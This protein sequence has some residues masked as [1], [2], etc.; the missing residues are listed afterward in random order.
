MEEIK[1]VT[2]QLK[3]LWAKMS[4]RSRMGVG[5]GL[6]ITLL[7]LATVSLTSTSTFGILYKLDDAAEAAEVA[8]VLDGAKIKYKSS[9]GGTV[10]E[11]PMEDIDRARMLLASQRLPHG[12]SVGFSDIYDDPNPATTKET[13]RVNF[14]RA[15]QGELERTITSLDAIATARVHLTLPKRTVFKNE[16]AI[17]SASVIIDLRGRR[18]SRSNVASIQHLVA[19][20]VE[21][22]EAGSVVV[23]TTQ[24]ERLRGVGEH[25]AEGLDY[26]SQ[27]QKELETKVISQLEQIVGPGGVTANIEADIDFSKI[28]TLEETF[29]PEQIAIRSETTEE[30]VEGRGAGR[31]QGLAGAMAN[32]PGAQGGTQAAGKGTSSRKTSAKTYEVNRTVVETTA[33]GVQVRKLTVAVLLDGTYTTPED[34]GDP[35]YNARSPEE[36]ASF[37]KLV[38]NTVGYNSARGDR[39][40]VT[41]NQFMFRPHLNAD[42]MTSANEKPWWLSYALGAGAFVM[43]LVAFLIFRKKRHT[44]MDAE[45]IQYPTRV[46]EAQRALE[47][48]ENNQARAALASAQQLVA[49]PEME[50]LREEVFQA[51]SHDPERAAEVVKAWMNDSDAA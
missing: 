30:A 25:E 37:Q 6:L 15:L 3:E 21:R 50:Q 22:L 35:V 13:E 34:G 48:V 9:A 45:I 2:E 38:E 39:V 5:V 18:L 28:E 46:D 32:E 10:I 40:L 44:T 12:G 1:K 23:I 42:G 14:L 17:P 7:V 20:G 47:A 31:P 36:L 27:F 11:V 33:P 29:D 41:S 4:A 51:T 26:K 43:A 49:E 16:Q 19:A 8:A 24:G